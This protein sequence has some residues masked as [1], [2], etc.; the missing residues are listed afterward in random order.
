M[1]IRGTRP[2]KWCNPQCGLFFGGVTNDENVSK[3]AFIEADGKPTVI[4]GYSVLC[5]TIK[6]SISLARQQCLTNETLK[7][8]YFLQ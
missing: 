8:R 6:A 1:S 7:N 5:L 4:N 2:H 3:T